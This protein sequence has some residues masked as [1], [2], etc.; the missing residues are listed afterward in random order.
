MI[1]TEISDDLIYRMPVIFPRGIEYESNDIMVKVGHLFRQ[2]SDSELISGVLVDVADETVK[3]LESIMEDNIER[4]VSLVIVVYP[5][6]PTRDVHLKQLNIIQQMCNRSRKN[7]D[8]RILALSRKYG[9]DH[10]V[11][12]LPPTIIQAYFSNNEKTIF[13]IGSTGFMN[14][15]ST[16]PKRFNLFLNPDS[17]LQNEWRNWFQ[18][19]LDHS[20]SLNEDTMAIPYLIPAKGD[21]EAAIKWKEYQNKCHA[22][23]NQKKTGEINLFETEE[24]ENKEE[25]KKD[26]SWDGGL[27]ALD[28]IAEELSHTFSQGY[29]V[30][31]VEST[32]IKPLSIP[33]KASLLGQKT[34][35]TIGTL[36]QKQSFTLQILSDTSAQEI[37]KYRKI[38]DLLDLFS[39]PLGFGHRWVP[40]QVRRL[41]DK[42]LELRNAL[43]KAKLQKEIQGNGNQYISINENRYRHDLEAM[44][45]A[46]GENGQ[47]SQSTISEILRQ[48]T[49]R[50]D[51]ALSGFLCPRVIYNKIMSPKLTLDAPDENWSQLLELLIRSANF[52]RKTILDPYF[53]R[54]LPDLSTA[55]EEILDAMDIWRDT[56]LQSRDK[57]QAKKEIYE[58]DLIKNTDIDIKQRCKMVHSLIRKG[59]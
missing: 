24:G 41:L 38:N 45:R 12:A 21:M 14:H 17:I 31:T 37:E 22:K 10:E 32:R 39:Y 15:P 54:R 16:D 2:L 48:A 5:A 6:C 3:W 55:E 35:R 59:H 20:P 42:E 11:F 51:A 9:D 7:V 13:Y 53:L 4:R 49:E 28:A 36:T 18:Q 1:P 34:E 8:I 40:A 50:L 27:T 58:L 23:A 30:T 19:L 43:A 57:R 47:I 46:L 52:L 44:Y 25:I 26:R 29:L 33:V 56:I